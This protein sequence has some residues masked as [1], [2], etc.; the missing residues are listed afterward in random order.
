MLT[1]GAGR[2]PKPSALASRVSPAPDPASSLQTGP[3][4][5]PLCRGQ[6]LRVETGQRAPRLGLPRRGATTLGTQAPSLTGNHRRRGG[7]GPAATA[8]PCTGL[9]PLKPALCPP[10]SK[11]S[12]NQAPSPC[13]PVSIFPA[14]CQEA[15]QGGAR[16]VALSVT[17]LAPP[18]PGRPFRQARP[19]LAFAPAVSFS[20]KASAS[21]TWLQGALAR[22]PPSQPSRLLPQAPG[23]PPLPSFLGFVSSLVYN[24]PV[25]SQL[26]CLLDHSVRPR[27]VATPRPPV[28]PPAT[29]MGS[30][31]QLA[32]G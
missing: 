20:R 23:L 15:P 3:R 11:P 12:R 9:L 22:F 5:C 10:G 32:L 14:T 16:S 19:P 28:T 27:A 17:P 25:S 29:S 26:T 1:G 13:T 4:S 2:E 7:R 18:R 6:R 21:V 8:R 24:Q 31:I 30:G